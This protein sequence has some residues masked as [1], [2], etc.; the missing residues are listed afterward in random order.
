MIYQKI[1]KRVYSILEKAGLGDNWSKTFDIF[2]ITLIFL[3]MI[4]LSLE[5]VPF[6]YDRYKYYIKIFELISVIIFTLEYVLRIWVSVEA[7]GKT[8]NTKKRMKYLFSFMALIDLLAILPFFIQK[9]FLM[10]IR[11]LKVLRLLRLIR[12][13]K[14]G[15]YSNSIGALLRVFNKKKADLIIVY[16]LI[17]IVLI[18]AA[19]VMYI[20]ENE[21]QPEIFSNV[22][23]GMW[24]GMVTIAGIGYGD[25]YPI[26][27]VGKLLAG[28]IAIMGIIIFAIPVGILGSAFIEDLDLRK[29]GRL[30][31]LKLSGHIILCGYTKLT[32]EI[33]NAIQRENYNIRIVLV[34]EKP[35]PDIKGIIYVNADWTDINTLKHL[36]IENCHACI[37]FAE[38]P[39]NAGSN[40]RKDIVDMRAIFTIYKIKNE[41]PDVHTISEI[42][43]PE[44]IEMIKINLK[45]DEI[46]LKEVIDGNLIATCMKHPYISPLLYELMDLKGKIIK[47]I[48]ANEIKITE[49]CQYENVI[50]Y[51]IDNDIA[52]I[53]LIHQNKSKLSPGK[54]EL[55]YPEDRLLY[56]TEGE[57]S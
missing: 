36:S 3:N 21:A 17:M 4:N 35:N 1:R 40:S 28:I 20:A 11:F 50:R 22:F 30:K 7:L 29:K 48:T 45:G 37:I 41:Y 24:W 15:K 9:L 34:T 56:V 33:T 6:I 16:F 43:N 5:S 31:S 13:F 19:N 39:G 12:V 57:N 55:V 25:I 27:V 26:T 53:G 38:E 47:E 23:Q 51:G 46:I 42:I 49:S 44:R 52:F 14:V 2:I 54:T 32:K 10:D 8:S 18:I